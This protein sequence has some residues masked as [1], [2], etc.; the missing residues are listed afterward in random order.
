LP[1]LYGGG[2]V[3]ANR[4]LIQCTCS[5]HGGAFGFTNVVVS[6]RGDGT[7]ELDPH[8]DGSCVICLGEDAA[9]ALRDALTEWLGA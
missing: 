3:S 9:T 6:K 7:I 4:R 8:V 2:T 5:V 1:W